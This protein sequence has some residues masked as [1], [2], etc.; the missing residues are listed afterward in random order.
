MVMGGELITS[1]TLRLS[2]AATHR[3][4][5]KAYHLLFRVRYN[6]PFI[7]NPLINI[8]DNV[9][10]WRG[11]EITSITVLGIETASLDDLVRLVVAFRQ[12]FSILVSYPYPEGGYI[13]GSYLPPISGDISSTFIYYRSGETPPSI[14]GFAT[15]YHGKE[16]MVVGESPSSDYLSV[17][18]AHLEKCPHHEVEPEDIAC[19][20]SVVP[21]Q[22][23]I[24]L[25]RLAVSTT[26]EDL[27]PFIWRDHSKGRYILAV[28]TKAI[29]D[30]RDALMI[31]HYPSKGE[32][33]KNYVRYRMINGR[34]EMAFTEGVDDYSAKYVV[35]INVKDLPYYR[36]GMKGKRKDP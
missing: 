10:G 27:T 8:G 29:G 18:V 2:K 22:D 34:E 12:D 23:L 28:R 9:N 5:S 6:K 21:T 7:I 17:P 11:S 15:G 26:E 13:I 36:L 1:L 3:L 20:I 30:G 25:V 19:D 14:I 35:V 16:R 33:E 4:R 32:E 24:S 31:F